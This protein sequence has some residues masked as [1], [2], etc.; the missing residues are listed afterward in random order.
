MKVKNQ[1]FTLIEL[2]VVIVIIGIL[3]GVI[4]IS[5]S[6]SIDKA[7]IAKS[8][9]FEESVKNNLLL[10]LIS[11]WNFDDTSSPYKDHWGSAN[12]SLVVPT[13]IA[14][15]EIKT[16]DCISNSCLFF[17]HNVS[18]NENGSY[19]NCGSLPNSIDIWTIGLWIKTSD[20]GRMP[21]SVGNAILYP[22]DGIAWPG[23][24][25][26]PNIGN[27]CN[28]EWH[29]LVF[30]YSGSNLI[31]GNN[32]FTYV[33]GKLIVQGNKSWGSIQS[34]IYIGRGHSWGSNTYPYRGLIDEINVY[35][36]YT[37]ASQI[38]QNYIA[39]LNLMLANGSISKEEY[40]QRI[41]SLGS[42]FE[43]NTK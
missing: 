27:V 21:L 5:T 34:P 25:W 28:D 3:T 30:I 37:S 24:Y 12:C 38:K 36:N 31:N 9:V 4:M 11:E 16:S 20:N 10:S 17:G 13:G 15:P 26:Y 14:S 2:L 6:S 23:N 32:V 42:T 1:S 18:Y 22:N 39:G 8:K 29:Y 19:L 40:N 35:N 7:N 41:E 43:F 33:D